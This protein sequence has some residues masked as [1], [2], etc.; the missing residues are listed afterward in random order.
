MR[1]VTLVCEWAAETLK[2]V[3]KES[4]TRFERVQ[5]HSAQGERSA[6]TS[7]ICENSYIS[8]VCRYRINHD[9]YRWFIACRL[10]AN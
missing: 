2:Q 3:T 10:L 6:A 8:D 1:Q 7:F 5:I 9:R 4:G